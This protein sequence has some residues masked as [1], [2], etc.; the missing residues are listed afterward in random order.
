[1]KNG[2]SRETGNIWYTRHRMKTRKTKGKSRMD[3]PTG[4]I[5]Y[6]RHRTKTIKT[7][8]QSRMDNPEKL[9]TLGTQDRG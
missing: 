4:N 9:T 8:G 7:E 6:T 3:N 2:Q 5:W 1:M